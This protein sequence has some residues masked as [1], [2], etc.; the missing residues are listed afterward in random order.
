[1]K[2]TPKMK[3]TPK[4]KTTSKKNAT[5]T[6]ETTPKWSHCRVHYILPEKKV[7]RTPHLDRQSTTVPKPEMLS[8]EKMT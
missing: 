7:L 1:M 2:T 8:K 6:M 4:M 5:S 3:M